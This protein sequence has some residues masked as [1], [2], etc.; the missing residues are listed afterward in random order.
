MFYV[1]NVLCCTV[2]LEKRR[3]ALHFSTKSYTKRNFVFESNIQKR[4][5]NQRSN[6]KNPFDHKALQGTL[7]VFT[8]VLDY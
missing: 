4:S 1:L 8:N 7:Y 3:K 5:L 2:P 6:K